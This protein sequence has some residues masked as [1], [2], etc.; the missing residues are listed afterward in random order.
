[1]FVR[2]IRKK[3]FS[4]ENDCVKIIYNIIIDFKY[5]HDN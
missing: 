5:I 3:G 4:V 2:D 1:M